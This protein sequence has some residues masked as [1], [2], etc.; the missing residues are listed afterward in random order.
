M[1]SFRVH[2]Q[3]SQV[4]SE[5]GSTVSRREMAHHKQRARAESKMIETFETVDNKFASA[6]NNISD[7]ASVRSTRSSAARMGNLV[8]CS[9]GRYSVGRFIEDQMSA[10]TINP[11]HQMYCANDFDEQKRTTTGSTFGNLKAA[12]RFQETVTSQI[13]QAHYKK[14]KNQQE[15]ITNCARRHHPLNYKSQV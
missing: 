8:A 11:G 4:I 2:H 12:P 9:P 7:T 15:T 6:N 13:M 5:K 10:R 3:N 1:T 14:A